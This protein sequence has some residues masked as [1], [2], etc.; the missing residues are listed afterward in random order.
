MTVPL[1]DIPCTVPL[2]SYH[3]SACSSFVV[4]TGQDETVA[5]PPACPPTSWKDAYACGQG[6]HTPA[7]LLWPTGNTKVGICPALWK[8][9]AFDPHVILPKH[10]LCIIAQQFKSTE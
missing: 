10:S 6:R 2:K 5:A 7:S 3:L 1:S 4:I 9:L 8:Q